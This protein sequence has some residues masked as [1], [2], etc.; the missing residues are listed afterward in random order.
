MIIHTDNKDALVILVTVVQYGHVL[1][2]LPYIQSDSS[3]V[4]MVDY[5]WHDNISY[6]G[7]SS[8]ISAKQIMQAV[9]CIAALHFVDSTPVFYPV[10]PGFTATLL[11][12]MQLS[13]TK[14]R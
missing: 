6:I 12:P 11:L 8:A 9:N 1:D 10:Y 13:G 7:V 2:M 14:L 3:R 5:C 4:G